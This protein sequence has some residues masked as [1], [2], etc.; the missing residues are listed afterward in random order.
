[1]SGASGDYSHA[2]GYSTA[3]GEYSHSEG[4]GT[5]AS[6]RGSHA[7][8]IDDYSYVQ[9]IGDGS[10]AEGNGT[11][12]YGV[13]SHTEGT[14]TV[15]NND[16]EHAQGKY[17]QSNAGDTDDKK[18]LHSIGIGTSVDDRKNAQEVMFNG[19]HY[20]IGIGGYDG[21]NPESAETLQE[22]INK[23]TPTD[24]P[25][26]KTDEGGYILGDITNKSATNEES[27]IQGYIGKNGYDGRYG[28]IIASGKGSIAQGCIEESGKIEASGLGSFA[29]GEIARDINIIASGTGSFAGGYA[30]TDNGD[31]IDSESTGIK[32]K[33][34]GSL[35]YGYLTELAENPKIEASGPG[36]IALGFSQV[37]G[38]IASGT[39]ALACGQPFGGTTEASGDGSF[40]GGSGGR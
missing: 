36:S 26:T 10:H 23:S 9:S 3:S 29:S 4:V 15:S 12:A 22:V 33:G 19:D 30:T 38:I 18:T 17:N 27:Y 20:I 24:E 31:S 13:A 8:G 21:T 11:E 35:A 37:G 14:Q 40:A 2:E 32:A 1:M 39:G 34:M 6:G 7:E 5:N 25:I 16:S 28:K